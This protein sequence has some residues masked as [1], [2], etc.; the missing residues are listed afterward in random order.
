VATKTGKEVVGVLRHF[1]CCGAKIFTGSNEV[2]M[3]IIEESV[4][5][6]EFEPRVLKAW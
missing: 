3:K 4:T 6:G 2:R 5:V 1:L